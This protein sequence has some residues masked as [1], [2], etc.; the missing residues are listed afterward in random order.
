MP[1]KVIEAKIRYWGAGYAA[2]LRYKRK[3]LGEARYRDWEE[4]EAERAIE[5]AVC[6]DA[7]RYGSPP[8]MT[9]CRFRRARP[10]VPRA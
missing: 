5:D 7:E 3:R 4:R 1:N 9:G 10:H 2:E 8:Q 6:D